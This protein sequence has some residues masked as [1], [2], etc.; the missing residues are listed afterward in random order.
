VKNVQDLSINEIASTLRSLSEKARN[1][2]LAPGDFSGA[3]FTVSNIGSVGGG[4]V[5]PVISEPQVAI[6][7]VGRS[8]VVPAFNENDELVK[9]E[10]LVLSWSAD[11]RV[12]DGA[13]CARCA[14]RVK[15]YLEDPG[16]LLVGLR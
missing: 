7:G 6:L 5:A 12:V 16:S 2:K 1:N 10:E 8:K 11:H 15:N 4:V 13:E 3:T 9:K 14:E